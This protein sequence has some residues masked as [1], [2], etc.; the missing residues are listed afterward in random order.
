MLRARQGLDNNGP[1]LR[2]GSG[3]H[4]NAYPG[5]TFVRFMFALFDQVI[6]FFF[7][8]KKPKFCNQSPINKFNF[9]LQYKHD[10]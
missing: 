6:F 5:S 7:K 4:K 9:V 1:W 10:Y 8:K 3:R 2:E